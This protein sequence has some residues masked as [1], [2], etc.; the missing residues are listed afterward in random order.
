MQADTIPSPKSYRITI[1]GTVQGVGFRP[2]VYRIAY[3]MGL[4]GTV[5]NG[6]QGV[7]IELNATEGER[8]VFVRRLRT[9]A[10]PLARIDSIRTEAIA[11]QSYDDFRII[12]STQTGQTRVRI[13]PDTSLC[14]ACEA[15]LLDPADRRYRY[16]FISCTEC[17]VRYSIIETLPYDRPN[18]SMRFFPMCDACRAEYT[19]PLNR[20]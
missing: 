12:P 17:G 7:I 18:T 5:S 1:T 11:P 14:P 8:V 9:E 15:E 3:D 19:N 16:P 13:P 20:R 6:T 4:C 10:P 2:F